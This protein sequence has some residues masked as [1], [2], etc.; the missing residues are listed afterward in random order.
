MASENGVIACATAHGKIFLWD[1]NDTETKGIVNYQVH[2]NSIT[3]LQFKND[4]LLSASQVR[5]FKIIDIKENVENTWM[6]D[7]YITALEVFPDGMSVL[8][9]F[10]DGQ[11]S[12][13]NLKDKSNIFL[14]DLKSRVVSI[15]RLSNGN[16]VYATSKGILH[17]FNSAGKPI[18]EI[19]AFPPDRLIAM[20][21]F[22]D[23]TI[24]V[25][26]EDNIIKLYKF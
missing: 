25:C 10:E 11:T 12:I 1:V 19:V 20:D 18:S 3:A 6:H 23:D 14:K 2:S 9:G 4:L 15:K 7:T 13:I 5:T 22:K 17:V 21:K 16:V 24:V 26:S 8:A